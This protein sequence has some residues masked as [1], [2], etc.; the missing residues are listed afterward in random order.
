MKTND[1][2]YFR[3]QL[4]KQRAEILALSPVSE[5]DG[6]RVE[7]GDVLDFA[8]IAARSAEADVVTRIAESE[9]KLLQKIDSALQR[10]DDG[11]YGYCAD[12]EV[13]I[14]CARLRAKPAFP[15]LGL[16]D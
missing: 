7:T 8:E 10:L 5:K 1:P 3:S 15:L 2:A 13:K 9:I 16:P 4:L 11:T 6:T 12:C 14:P